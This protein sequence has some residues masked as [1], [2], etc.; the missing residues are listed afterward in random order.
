MPREVYTL[1]AKI[2][3]TYLREIKEIHNICDLMMIMTKFDK[4]VGQ[5]VDNC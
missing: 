4:K 5:I 2:D 1:V 3:K